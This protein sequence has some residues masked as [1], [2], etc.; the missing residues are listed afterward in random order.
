MTGGVDDMLTYEQIL[1]LTPKDHCGKCGCL[2][3][4]DYARRVS[5]KK[6]DAHECVRLSRVISDAIV[7]S[8]EGPVYNSNK[9]TI[10]V[11]P[12]LNVWQIYNITPQYD[13]KI[14]GCSSCAEFA[15]QVISKRAGIYK[16]AYI[17]SDIKYAISA[18]L[19]SNGKV[20]YDR[21]EN[22]D[23]LEEKQK[24]EMAFN[25]VQ[26]LLDIMKKKAVNQ[27]SDADYDVL[28]KGRGEWEN[29]IEIVKNSIECKTVKNQSANKM[30]FCPACGN[31]VYIT[32][33]N[34]EVRCPQCKII[35]QKRKK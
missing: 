14:C 15:N 24:I 3:C 12:E 4:F 26:L 11:R 13:C 23:K 6:M 27:M 16:C 8:V 20:S 7:K 33:I 31:K 19:N 34:A 10:G 21:M 2:T 5:N 9:K 28:K 18:Y 17:P 35:V 1:D 22:F 30:I 32:D 25:N 29:S